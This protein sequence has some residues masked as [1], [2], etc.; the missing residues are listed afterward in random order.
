MKT[1]KY[2][3]ITGMFILMILPLLAG[4]QKVQVGEVMMIGTSEWKKNPEGIKPSFKKTGETKTTVHLLR[5][6]RGDHNGDF[7]L[8][9]SVPKVVDRS[10]LP[11]GNPFTDAVISFGKSKNTKPSTFIAKPGAYSEYR[12]V[13][14]D[15]FTSL[16]EVSLL[17]IH[18]IKVKP[19]RAE[20]FEKFV[21]EK[22]HPA[23]GHVL[24]D[25]QLLYYKAVAGDNTGSYITIFTITSHAAREKYWPGGKP[26]TEIL[27]QAFL[28]L[29]GLGRE[30]QPYLV[31]NS[32]LE[33]TGGAAAYFESKEWTDYLVVN[34]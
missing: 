1:D 26:E 11:G 7:L 25:M 19:D 17:G 13:G 10:A 34:E 20:D 3:S 32:Y 18:Y 8:V 14:A 15:K 6:D 12:L 16:P 21:V 22:L 31:E 5:A 30:L 27:K 9:C 24:A 23:V 2:R 33:E 4:A 28:P 29:R